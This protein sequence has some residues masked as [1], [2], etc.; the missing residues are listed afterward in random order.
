MKSKTQL[1]NNCNVVYTNSASEAAAAG[2]SYGGFKLRYSFI[3]S[4]TD[5]NYNDHLQT[6]SG[7]GAMIQNEP[8]LDFNE[9][10]KYNNNNYDNNIYPRL[11]RTLTLLGFIQGNEDGDTKI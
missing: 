4:N 11:L 3:F 7:Q 6:P 1:T 10:N 5:N 9:N 8:T 2:Q